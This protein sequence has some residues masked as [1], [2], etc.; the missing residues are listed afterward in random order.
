M[1]PAAGSVASSKGKDEKTT[2]VVVSVTDNACAY[3][4]IT[5][6]IYYR[7]PGNTNRRGVRE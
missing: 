5:I 7:A 1:G 4:T 2:V 6:V 3:T